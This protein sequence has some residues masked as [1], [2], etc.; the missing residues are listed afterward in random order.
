[1]KYQ[2]FTILWYVQFL[3]AD[4]LE[5]NFCGSWVRLNSLG[6]FRIEQDMDIGKEGVTFN[7]ETLEQDMDIG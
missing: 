5:Y 2:G 1:M 6:N 4:F 3:M 7:K